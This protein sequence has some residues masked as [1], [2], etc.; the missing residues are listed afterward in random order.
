MNGVHVVALGAAAV[1]IGYLVSS[2][3]KGGM[4]GGF[5][6]P[7]KQAVADSDLYRMGRSPDPSA[8]CVCSADQHH[9]GYTYTPHRYPRTAGGEI[10]AII[11]RGYSTMR[12]PRSDDVQ[13]MIAPPS[14]VMW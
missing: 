4:T 1:G 6:A 8:P 5:N 11:H 9:S 14:E 10:T 12:I 2:Q 3:A 13:W 7:D